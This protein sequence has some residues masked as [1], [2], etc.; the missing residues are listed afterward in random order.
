MSTMLGADRVAMIGLF[1]PKR[2]F[3]VRLTNAIVQIYPS[4]TT[5]VKAKA[6]LCKLIA[7][8]ITAGAVTLTVRV[9][10]S[11]GSANTNALNDLVSAESVP[12]NGR[13]HI[14]FGTDGLV[15]EAGDAISALAGANTAINLWGSGGEEWTS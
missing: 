8:N 12:A 2:L 10:V 9:T 4:A 5:T 7:T 6:V 3:R 1:Q 14:D 11:G 13:L 15:L